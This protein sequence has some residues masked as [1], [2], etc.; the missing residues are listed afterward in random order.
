MSFHLLLINWLNN[1]LNKKYTLL[2]T[3]TDTTTGKSHAVPD[4]SK[5]SEI[6]FILY[7]NSGCGELKTYPYEI[8]AT[9]NGDATTNS[10]SRPFIDMTQIQGNISNHISALLSVKSSTS[11]M[12]EAISVN[13][14][15]TFNKLEIYG[16]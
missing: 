12:V 2:A 8:L 14:Y 6:G 1:S 16:K 10:S 15:W 4:M 11:I 5:Y 7:S 13:G 3:I 9:L